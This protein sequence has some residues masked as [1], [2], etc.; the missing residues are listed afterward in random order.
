MNI[1]E[2]KQEAKLWIDSNVFDGE[3]CKGMGNASWVKH[4]ADELYD[5][6]DDMLEHLNNNP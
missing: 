4:N 6:I 5:L 2:L 3:D 1:E